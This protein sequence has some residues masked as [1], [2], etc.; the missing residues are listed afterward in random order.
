MSDAKTTDLVPA[1]ANQAPVEISCSP[2]IADWLIANKVSLGF[3][4][5]QSG[6]LYLVSATSSGRLSFHERHL[7]RA[8]G[9]WADPQRLLIATLFQLW[10]FENILAPGERT[11]EGA[12][13]HYVP[14]VAHTTGDIDVHEIGVTSSG[15]IVFVNTL[16]SCLAELSP[17]HSFKPIWKPPF[18]SAL[19]PEDR[20]HMNG[21]G[22][23]DG[24]PRYVTSV[25][26]TDVAGG[27]RRDRSTGGSLI[28]ITT[29]EIITDR[30]SMPHS[31]RWRDGEVWL[32]NSGSGHLGTVDQ[33][34]G[35]F[36]PKVFC[37]GFLRGF[38]FHNNHA[39]VGLSLPRGGN[40]SGLALD[41][42][43]SKRKLEPWCGVQIIDLASGRV[44]E[45][46]R[47]QGGVSELFDVSVL[48][49]VR[50]ATAT[51]LV[52]EDIQKI[53]SIDQWGSIA[54]GSA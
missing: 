47:L 28:D 43:L 53:V 22:M 35:A 5:Y 51:G 14:R 27:W 23:R 32:L 21:L 3:T 1:D 33:A 18:I 4:S 25:S 39:I 37:P 38:A 19:A 40:F 46:I 8:M 29:N 41:G 34:T 11:T 13:R 16:Y 26:Q 42:E 50:H 31:P 52:T 7:A 36:E 44:A 17:T 45:W 6:R 48:P 54:S 24:A 10:R 9:L 49:G 20:C 12:D 15:R 2:G 30:L